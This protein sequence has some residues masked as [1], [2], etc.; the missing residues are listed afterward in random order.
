[1]KLLKVTELEKVG[2]RDHFMLLIS[3]SI[4]INGIH[5]R[6]SLLFETPTHIFSGMDLSCSFNIQNVWEG[7]IGASVTKVVEVF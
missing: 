7:V 6:R 2:L 5:S 1:M 4:P 3:I